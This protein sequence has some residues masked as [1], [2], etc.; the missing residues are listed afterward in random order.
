VI[1]KQRVKKNFASEAVMSAGRVGSRFWD[2]SDST[3][4]LCRRIV[5]R[6]ILDRSGYSGVVTR[7]VFRS[8]GLS[9]QPDP[10]SSRSDLNI[11]KPDSTDL[12]S[13]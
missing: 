4:R 8:V 12:S 2:V 9:P 13:I 10:T 7:P 1:V 11:I 6:P 5:T 3:G